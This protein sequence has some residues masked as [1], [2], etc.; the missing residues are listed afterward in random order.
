MGTVLTII[1]VVAIIGALIG[2][3]GSGG[4]SEDAA[5][6]AAAGAMFAG[7]CMFQLFI[8]GLMA[9]AGIWLIKTIFF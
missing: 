1:A 9:L 8:Y 6:G 4:K 5:A 3:F 2:F 7:G